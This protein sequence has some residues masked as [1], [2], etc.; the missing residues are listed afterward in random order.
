MLNEDKLV[1]SGLYFQKLINISLILIL[2][3]KII[4]KQL[5]PF[6]LFKNCKTIFRFSFKQTKTTERAP[7]AMRS[8]RSRGY[9]AGS[10]PSI[11][12]M[13]R[14]FPNLTAS[15][16]DVIK[17]MSCRA[18]RYRSKIVRISYFSLLLTKYIS[19]IF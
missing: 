11:S 5:L 2:C 10:T 18:Q 17:F 9:S 14:V 16:N 1:E 8:R 13:I 12:R 7:C 15:S 6:K 19:T 4:R 3:Q